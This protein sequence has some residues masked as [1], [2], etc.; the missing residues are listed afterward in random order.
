VTAEVSV[1]GGSEDVK[2]VA[3]GGPLPRGD[4]RWLAPTRL[5]CTTRAGGVSGGKSS[6]WNR[7]A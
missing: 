4:D 7:G 1:E 5:L 3:N 2:R 6:A